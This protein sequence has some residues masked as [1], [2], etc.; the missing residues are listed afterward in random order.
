VPKFLSPLQLTCI[1]LRGPLEGG[2]T[3]PRT[4]I[5]VDD[6]GNEYH[7][8]LKLRNPDS[9]HGRGH[10]GAT[11]LVCEL[12]CSV[13]AQALGLPVPKYAVV[14]V[15]EPL[16]AAQ[17]LAEQRLL[18]KNLG[19]NFGC[20]FREGFELWHQQF[21]TNDSSLLATLEATLTFDATV[22]NGDRNVEKPNLL[23]RGSD[24]LLIDHSLAL[25]CHLWPPE[26]V[27]SATLLPEE[28]V[29]KHAAYGALN[30]RGRQYVTFLDAW[31]SKLDDEFLDELRSIIPA[32]WQGG[33]AADTIFTF[34]STRN[35][36][37]DDITTDLQRI[38]Q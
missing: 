2:Q 21:S 24:L 5:A 10:F 29:R 11:S 8:V 27:T 17:P 9:R 13:L 35:R 4:A 30:R 34:L 19:P 23:V 25:P 31:A 32:E 18:G 6:K 14:A 28:H 20:E 38:V 15:T 36:H 7:I 16:A 12:V 33:N 22:F 1:E 26:A 3:K 37:H